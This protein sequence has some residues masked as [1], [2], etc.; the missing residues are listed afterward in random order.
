MSFGI[1]NPQI[2]AYLAKTP[3]GF[4]KE[5]A[6]HNYAPAALFTA[7]SISVTSIIVMVALTYLLFRKVELK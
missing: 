6:L 1:A 4:F 2:G 7:A 3:L 5:L